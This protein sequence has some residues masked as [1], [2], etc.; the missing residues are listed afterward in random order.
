MEEPRQ[1]S[2]GE[3][4]AMRR[5]IAD[6]ERQRADIDSRLSERRA[7]FRS[8]PFDADTAFEVMVDTLGAQAEHVK[9]DII[10]PGMGPYDFAW[11]EQRP[12][13]STTQPLTT[14]GTVDASVS[15]S[16]APSPD[17]TAASPPVEPA[18]TPSGG[19]LD[20]L[21]ADQQAAMKAAGLDSAEMIRIAS[22]D[23]LLKVEGIGPATLRK[24]REA[25]AE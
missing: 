25:T 13:E 10:R 21:D 16:L 4:E 24:L 1:A 5:E 20:V 2:A 23:D 19:P 14:E 12:M 22:D 9:G 7:Q 11:L 8:G 17:L 15:E 3:R 18:A 6:L